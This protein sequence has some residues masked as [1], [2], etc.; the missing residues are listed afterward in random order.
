M[1]PAVTVMRGIEGT[2]GS[3]VSLF[4]ERLV[5][6][7]QRSDAVPRRVIRSAR[8]PE[9]LDDPRWHGRTPPRAR[10]RQSSQ[11]RPAH[12]RARRRHQRVPSRSCRRSTATFRS[13]ARSRSRPACTPA[14]SRSR[15]PTKTVWRSPSPTRR[16]PI[17]GFAGSV[18]SR[19]RFPKGGSLS[20][21]AP[22]ARS[23][24]RAACA[25]PARSPTIACA[26]RGRSSKRRSPRTNPLRRSAAVVPAKTRAERSVTSISHRAGDA[27]PSCRSPIT[28]SDG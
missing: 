8:G 10:R 26:S 11:P 19:A 16:A 4:R 20:S 17:R 13:T 18:R 5:H 28:T 7:T 6:L 25:R 1:R 15:S 12:T 9:N 24:S 3:T 27:L 2:N 21:C 22:P 23:S 14:R